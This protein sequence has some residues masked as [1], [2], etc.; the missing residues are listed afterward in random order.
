MALFKHDRRNWVE[1]RK[2]PDLDEVD[3]HWINEKSSGNYYENMDDVRKIALY[4]LLKAQQEGRQYV[5]LIHGWFTSRIGK[6]T[7]RSQIRG[8]MKHKD[9]T[10]YIIRKNCIQHDTV[11]VAAIKSLAAA[12]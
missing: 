9:A 1:F 6:T 8:L 10:P 5:L 4:S 2:L 7:S 3:F 11:F 12:S